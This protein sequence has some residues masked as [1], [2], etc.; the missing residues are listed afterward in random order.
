MNENQRLAALRQELVDIE[1]QSPSLIIPALF[2]VA[3][4]T[5]S[6]WFGSDTPLILAMIILC[7]AKFRQ[8]IHLSRLTTIHAKAKIMKGE[9]P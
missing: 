4:L 8:V 2:V 9:T 7:E 3:G 5:C 6:Y 1:R